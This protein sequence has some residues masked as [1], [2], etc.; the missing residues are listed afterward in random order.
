MTCWG[1]SKAEENPQTGAYSAGCKECTA[2]ALAQSPAYDTSRRAGRFTAE[3]K[4]VLTVAFGDDWQA[5]HE[6][7]KRW[8][9]RIALSKM[10]RDAEALGL[11]F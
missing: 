5:G 1:C 2:R 9:Q 10:A 11:D 8:S 6:Q 7:V 3:Y 4:R